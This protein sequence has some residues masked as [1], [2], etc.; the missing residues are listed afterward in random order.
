MDYFPLFADL[1]N[2]PCLIVGGGAVASR[3]LRQLR[4]AGARVTVNA[5][6]LTHEL[7]ELAET[8]EIAHAAGE[9][10]P[11]LVHKNLLIIAATDD[12]ETNHAVAAAA[13]AAQRL[14]NVVDD[15]P[16]C[17]FI[18]PSVVDRSP[19]LIAVSS[20]GQAPMLARSLRQQIDGWLPARVTNL[21]RWISR[22][23][24][25]VGQAL[26]AFQDRVQFWQQALDG[27]PAEQVLAGREAAADA[28]LEAQLSGR[29]AAR[30]EAWLVGAG[31]GDPD[32]ITQRGLTLLQRADA[33][34]YD[35]LVAPALLDHARRDA[36]LICVGKQGGGP[37]VKQTDI[38]K[39]LISRVQQG[40]RVCRLKG[41][42]PFIFGRGGEEL[43][44]LVDAGLPYQV[45]PGITA[46]AGCAAY[47]G[48]P[49]THRE[50]AAGVS[51]VTGHRADGAPATDF[52]PLVRSGQT[53]AIYM[54]GR[55]LEALC[56]ELQ[57]HGKS[58]DTPVALIERGTTPTQCVTGGTLADLATRVDN[59]GSPALL[60]VGDVVALSEN[61]RWFVSE[62]A[63]KLVAI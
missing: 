16:A 51:F 61:L 17:S 12:R 41:G 54:G 36:E 18:V 20:G 3:K 26:P 57:A 15:G 55:R 58:P 29:S 27:A 9:F 33:V 22:W 23:R 11:A 31:P 56:K 19:L 28:L 32:L 53:L 43:Q 24:K 62:S 52:E 40:Q 39:E 5:P 4:R 1:K 8:G 25:R 35:R 38:N 50:L 44:S 46:A 45:V 60:I 48:I 2:R 7:K 42:D 49:L 59:V 63:D 30:G 14:C 6:E 10:D 21:A 13:R 47:A 37:A 34:L